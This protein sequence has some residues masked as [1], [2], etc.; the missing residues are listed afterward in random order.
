VHTAPG[1]GAPPLTRNTK[2]QVSSTQAQLPGSFSYRC[3]VEPLLKRHWGTSG[4]QGSSGGAKSHSRM[5][6]PSNGQGEVKTGEQP[7]RPIWTTQET[8]KATPDVV[9]TQL[10]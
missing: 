5:A 4:R 7:S 6:V 1:A 8:V 2:R 3:L 9:P 10:W